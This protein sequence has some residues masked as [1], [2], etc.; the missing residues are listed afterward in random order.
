MT[1]S[2]SIQMKIIEFSG[3]ITYPYTSKIESM[4]DMIGDFVGV[5]ALI[6]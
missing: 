2:K 5:V 4:S 6:S 1:L 3:H